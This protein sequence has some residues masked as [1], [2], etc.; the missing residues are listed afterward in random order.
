MNK[1]DDNYYNDDYCQNPHQI[2]NQ[3]NINS[4]IKKFSNCIT[5]TTI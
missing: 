2:N 3:N 1:D 4:N 5:T